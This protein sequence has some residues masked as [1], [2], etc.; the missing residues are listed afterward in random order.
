MRVSAECAHPMKENELTDELISRQRPTRA[1][2]S[3]AAEGHVV[4]FRRSAGYTTST[5]RQ[6]VRRL[7][8]DCSRRFSGTTIM[9]VSLAPKDRTRAGVCFP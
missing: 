5:G 3:G 4:R 2:S 6:V 1:Q 9:T 8:G 7:I